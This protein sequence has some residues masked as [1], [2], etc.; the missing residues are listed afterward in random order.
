MRFGTYF[1]RK[2]KGVPFREDKEQPMPTPAQRRGLTLKS[3]AVIVL[4]NVGV[5]ATTMYV[6]DRWFALK[7]ATFDIKGYLAGQ[8]KLFYQ[9]KITEE[10][11][12]EGLDRVDA[13]LRKE[14]SNTVIFNGEAVIRNAKPIVIP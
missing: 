8:K 12:F 1:D 6:Y 2:K 3:L 5:S 10:E 11:M 9:G 14:P 4:L 13:T 7:V